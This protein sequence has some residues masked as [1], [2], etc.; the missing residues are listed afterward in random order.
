M[1]NLQTGTP[2]IQIGVISCSGEE[3]LGG[4]LTRMATR[5]VM[6]ELR[7]GQVISLCLPLFIAGGE[8]ERNFARDFPVISVDACEKNCAKKSIEKYSG[9]VRDF[10]VLTEFFDREIIFSKTVSMKDMTKEHYEMVD[11]I[12]EEICKKVDAIVAEQ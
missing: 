9:Q 10:V 5:K 3:M 4:T 7:P 1:S 8:E 11:K 12:A 2:K 6:E